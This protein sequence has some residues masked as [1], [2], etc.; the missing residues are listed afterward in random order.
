MTETIEPPPLHLWSK[1]DSVSLAINTPHDLKTCHDSTCPLSCCFVYSQRTKTLEVFLE[2]A[3]HSHTGLLNVLLWH[4]EAQTLNLGVSS[5]LPI[6]ANSVSLL[7]SVC[8]HLP[9]CLFFLITNKWAK[10]NLSL[11][12]PQTSFLVTAA[13]S[14]SVLP[15]LVQHTL[16]NI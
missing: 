7:H 4:L 2:L 6:S 15:C 8:L 16:M 3:Q 12:L 1:D 5:L 11:H 13:A 9:L 14:P 10:M